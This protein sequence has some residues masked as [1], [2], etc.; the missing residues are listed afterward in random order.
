MNET[1][2]RYT[3]ELL[4]QPNELIEVR[5][6]TSKSNFSGYFKN[7]D[8][9][10]RELP[11]FSNGNVYFV[12]NKISDACYSRE[13]TE[14]F[15]EKAKNTTS[16]NDIELRNWLLID[17]DPKRPAGV[18]S[19]DTEKS[20]AKSVINKVF[21]FLRDIGFSEPIV[22]DSGNGFHLLYK[23]SLE[24][25]EQNKLLIQVIL[26]LLDLYFSDSNCE[27]DKTVF[28]ASR[29]TKLYGTDSKKGNS[30]TDR[31]HRQ[32]SILRVPNE[33]KETPYPLL[34]KVAEMFPKPEIKSFQNNYGNDKFN[35]RDFIQKHGIEVKSELNF[36]GG[37]KFILEHCLFDSSHKAK[38]AAIFELQNGAI[39]YKCLHNSCSGYKWQDVRKLFEPNAY[40]RQYESHI[41]RV[42]EKKNE[43][44][45]QRQT[46][47]KGNKF[48]NFKDIEAKD[49]TQ[50]VSIPSGFEKLDNKIIGFNK[51]EVSL[52]SGKNGS[53]KST[54]LNQIA[55]NSVEKGF[56]GLIFSGELPSHKMKNWIHLQC[57]GRQFTQR[58][59]KYEN[60]FFVK[61]SISDK[62]DS[63]LNNKLLVYN[64]EYGNDFEQLM[65]DIEEFV[66][67][68][69]IDFVILDNLMALD[70]LTLEGDKYQQQTRFVNRVCSSVRKLNYHLHI[71]AH[72]RKQTGFL[73]KDDISGTA[74]LTN[75]VD[76]VLICHRNNN[77]YK[78]AIG[79]FFP[80]ELIGELTQ[81]DNYIEVCKNRD[82][83]VIDVLVGLYYEVE[84]KRLL[85]E[86]FENK[87][88]GWQ[89]V[90]T[91]LMIQPNIRIEPN[92][93]FYEQID[94]PFGSDTTTDE[95]PF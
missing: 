89:D 5:C 69:N 91:Q 9:I 17:V 29:I 62:I 67:K 75:A 51:G 53:A 63:W 4:K 27:I 26:Q 44:I 42:T 32:S 20:N 76:N 86:M 93:S 60:M 68:N 16:D 18:S 19:T 55:I 28:N 36:Q 35:L 7:V 25:N 50:I 85:N 12:L 23:I 87:T 65:C 71:V 46:V 66:I 41:K 54:I 74:D 72:P 37:T 21:A 22:C 77:D 10:I 3:F 31:P 78:K 40:E 47:E 90:E 48:L 73:R 11:K 13:Q 33:I 2:I 1:Q 84:S 6:I 83:G 24:N 64:N 95:P 88:Y 8:N 43:I 92:T 81:H 94:D 59:E 61:K 14:Y 45:P 39:S 58:S 30:T 15:I 70:L 80:K 79:D 56:K 38:D 82:M 34:L 52:W 57:A 49:R